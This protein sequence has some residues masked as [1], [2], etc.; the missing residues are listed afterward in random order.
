MSTITLIISPY[1]TGLHAHRV[2]KGPHHIL[3]QNLLAQLTSLGL[4]IET[5]EIPRVDDFEGEIGRSFEVMRRTSLAV[6]EAVEKGNWPLVL[7]G[8]CMASVAVAC[9]LEHAQAQ[10]QG[11]K[12]G[13]RGKL[14]FIYF[15]SHDDL[16]SPDVNENGYFDAMGLSMLR[17]ESWKLLMNTV[18]G[19]DPESPFDYRSN[20]NRFLYVGLRDQSELQRERVVE[21]GMDSI[22]G[23]NLNP[24]DGLRG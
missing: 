17:G 4:N 2:G 20:K 21:A 19:Y 24:P 3:S 5:Y 15:D 14:G 12:K 13:G 1:H 6:S 9:G 18:P 23:G 8:N 16:D 7:S 10:A 11:Q 22:W